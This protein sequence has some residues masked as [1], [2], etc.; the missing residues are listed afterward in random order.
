MRHVLAARTAAL[1]RGVGR[2]GGGH[3]EPAGRA[4]GHVLHPGVAGQHGGTVLAH[5]VEPAWGE[6]EREDTLVRNAIGL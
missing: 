2:Q 4:L 1:G 5:G 6:R 3:Q